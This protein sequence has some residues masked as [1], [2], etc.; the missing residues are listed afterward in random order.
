MLFR[1]TREFIISELNKDDIKPDYFAYLYC[2]FFS[3]SEDNPDILNL[4]E[5][6]N[7]NDK[8]ITDSVREDIEI[9][10]LDKLVPPSPLSG[11]RVEV[12]NKLRSDKKFFVDTIMA[13]DKIKGL[14]DK[15]KNKKNQYTNTISK[16]LSKYRYIKF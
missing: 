1:S 13:L 2:K 8:K 11:T 7:S 9:M 10:G 5:F 6:F 4:F 14:L 3:L 16:Y 12:L 15:L